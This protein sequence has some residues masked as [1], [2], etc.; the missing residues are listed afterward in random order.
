VPEESSVSLS[1]VAFLALVAAGIVLPV[2]AY[3]IEPIYIP[4][5]SMEP[6]L[7]VGR[8]L[9]CD[10]LTLKRRDVRRG[11]IVVFRPPT[12]EDEEMVKRVIA[13]PG[14]TVELRDKQVS[15]DGKALSED[16]V[17]HKRAEEKLEGDN[18]GPIQV[19]EDSYF[20]LGDNR[21]E[22]NDSSVWKDKDGNHLYFVE[23]KAI[24]GLV[25]GVY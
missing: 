25:R 8:H 20:V 18:L 16:Y 2:R 4:S 23:R 15:I 3:V 24:T 17:Q 1:R 19:P 21:D 10:K 22:S 13:L 14:E 5:A 9:F 12:G 7:P 6:T 11:D